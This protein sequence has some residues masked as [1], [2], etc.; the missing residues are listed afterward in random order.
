MNILVTAYYAE[1]VAV[2]SPPHT[3]IETL[4]VSH[5]YHE[6]VENGPDDEDESFA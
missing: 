5:K 4:V 6:Y 3:M 1:I 2:A